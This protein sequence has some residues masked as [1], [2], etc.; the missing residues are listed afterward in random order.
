MLTL[1]YLTINKGFMRW[2]LR[3][4]P[5]HG[6]HAQSGTPPGAMMSLDGRANAK[7]HQTRMGAIA[8][9]E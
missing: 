9:P 8:E 1:L 7:I 2:M 3:D 5:V 6:W 4:A